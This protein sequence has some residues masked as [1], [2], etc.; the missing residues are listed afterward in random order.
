[1]GK[2]DCLKFF[3]VKGRY[4]EETRIFV[5]VARGNRLGTLRPNMLCNDN[6]NG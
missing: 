4:E 6:S 1:M 5:E 2:G 3:K